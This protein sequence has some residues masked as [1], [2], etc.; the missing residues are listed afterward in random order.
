MRSVRHPLAESLHAP[1]PAG[2][3]ITS[4]VG[5]LGNSSS[6][7]E[8][9]GLCHLSRARFVLQA[10]RERSNAAPSGLCWAVQKSPRRRT[11]YTS[12]FWN[13]LNRGQVGGQVRCSWI[14]LL[15][16]R[17]EWCDK[18]GVELYNLNPIKRNLNR[19]ATPFY[20]SLVRALENS[21]PQ[22]RSSLFENIKALL[23]LTRTRWEEVFW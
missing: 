2:L 5:F 6:F 10:P 17:C 20:A 21:F 11:I 9:L 3:L 23:F 22:R 16:R 13:F 14:S 4:W 8:F 12:T 7:V 18:L 15:R 1:A 19:R